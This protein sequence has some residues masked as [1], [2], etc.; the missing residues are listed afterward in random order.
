MTSCQRFNKVICTQHLPVH[1]RSSAKPLRWRVAVSIAS[2]YRHTHTPVICAV[3]WSY[4][5]FIYICGGGE[6]GFV[7]LWC[8]MVYIVWLVVVKH[9]LCPNIRDGTSFKKCCLYSQCLSIIRPQVSGISS[10]EGRLAAPKMQVVFKDYRH[11]GAKSRQARASWL[12]CSRSCMV[13][14]FPPTSQEPLTRA[15]WLYMNTCSYRLVRLLITN[16]FA[17]WTEGRI[18]TIF[19]S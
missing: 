8:K 2:M 14:K 11:H 17:G 15:H 4:A 18:K 1:R 7:I 13:N 3:C 6:D 12:V 16:T 10:A 5:A 19:G 9:V